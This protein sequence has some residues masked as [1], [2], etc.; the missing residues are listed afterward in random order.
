MEACALCGAETKN[1]RGM[2]NHYR[3][4]HSG[5]LK[6]QRW[7]LQGWIDHCID[8]DKP[9]GI[10][11]GGKRC[12][13]CAN[14]DIL[15]KRYKDPIEREK[16]H[17]RMLGKNKYKKGEEHKR[18]IS[19]AQIGKSFE[20]KVGK[21]KAEEWKNK[22]SKS[23][24]GNKKPARSTEH[25]EHLRLSQIKRYEKLDEHKKLSDAQ[26]KRFSNPKE[27]EKYR[28][29]ALKRIESSLK[30]GVQIAPNY[31]A[32]ACKIIDEYGKKQ[33]YNFQH[34]ENGGEIN[35]LGYFLD[36]YD[37]K[38]NIAIEIDEPYHFDVY[39]NLRKKDIMRQNEIIKE[40]NCK[41]IR[42][43]IDNQ[44]NIIRETKYEEA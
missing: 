7:E 17:Q 23:N 10:N 36:G 4:Y 24:K 20:D 39:G 2:G 27:R 19:E 5:V 33:K 34:A 1:R 35:I 21:E 13:S 3:T 14:S 30:N 22:I 26:I 16:Q 15:T 44:S 6:L 8:C 31:N 29:Y 43:K 38:N 25:C 37:V 18:K 12:Q 41:F 32:K 42:I 28:T 9:I 11:R 40:L